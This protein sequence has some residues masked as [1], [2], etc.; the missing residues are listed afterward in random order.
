MITISR[1]DTK[2]KVII[3]DGPLGSSYALFWD[4]RD[5]YYAELLTRHF[6]LKLDK[7][8]QTIREYEYRQ[9]Y[10]DGRA[11]RAKRNYFSTLLKRIEY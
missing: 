1:E 5:K 7:L 10:K 2:V 8:V 6:D 9:G 4:C 3:E 11:K